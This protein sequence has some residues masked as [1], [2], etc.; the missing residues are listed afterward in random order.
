MARMPKYAKMQNQKISSIHAP[1]PK[2]RLVAIINS[3]LFLWFLTAVFVTGA[4]RYF[5]QVQECA[6]DASSALERWET[7]NG[8]IEDRSDYY[9][10]ALRT[11]KTVAELKQYRYK[12]DVAEIADKDSRELFTMRDRILRMVSPEELE[13]ANF[14]SSIIENTFLQT[15]EKN[16]DAGLVEAKSFLSK[17]HE[18]RFATLRTNCGPPSIFAQLTSGTRYVLS[19]FTPLQVIWRI[20]PNTGKP[21]IQVK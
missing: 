1:P 9:R 15:V 12:S 4:G 5:T 20:D 14:A 10:H 19:V 13:K 2:H 21:N 17:Y 16:T 6:R 11:A 8:E 18:P 3:P 7:V